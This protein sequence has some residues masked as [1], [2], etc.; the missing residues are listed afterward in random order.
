MTEWLQTVK[1]GDGTSASTLERYD[2]VVRVH[3]IPAIGRIKL[4][5]LTPRDVQ[6]MVSQASANRRA[7]FGYQDPRRTSERSRRRRAHGPDPRNVAR[8]VRSATLTRTERR[9]LTPT[10]AAKLLAQ[11]EGDR[12]EG[13]F[14][15]PSP[16]D[17]GAAKSSACAG[18]HGC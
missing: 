3:I 17:C 10:E 5:A 6:L 12:L 16:L 18:G 14:V 7:G 2:Q 15:Q 13:V 8:A 4:T 11:L 9:A 1:A